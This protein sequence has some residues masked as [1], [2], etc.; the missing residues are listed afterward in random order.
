M[1]ETSKFF[2]LELATS[3]WIFFFFLCLKLATSLQIGLFMLTVELANVLFMLR[4][5]EF[6]LETRINR[7]N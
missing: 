1:L 6:K 4:C 5:F 2:I 7:S 3:L